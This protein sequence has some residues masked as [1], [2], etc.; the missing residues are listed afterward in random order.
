MSMANAS[1]TL[2]DAWSHFNNP[3]AI[4]AVENFT[5]G[6]SYENRFLLKELQSQAFAAAIPLKA[7]VVSAGGQ[8]FGYRDFRTYKAGVGYGLKLS[9]KL[10]A[11]VQM[12]YLGLQLNNA[13]GSKH[14]ISGDLGVLGKITDH[15]LFGVSVNNLFRAKLAEY[16]DDRFTTKMRF[17]SSYILSDKAII[18]GEVEKDITNP[19]RFKAGIEYKPIKNFCIRG[20]V[21][22]AP[23]ELSFGIGYKAEVITIDVGSSYHQILGWSPHFGLTFVNNK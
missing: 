3:G 17:G 4:G 23:V 15:W 22:T 18:A 16:Q 14:T 10:F 2:N 19:M 6:L 21:A 1:V 11:G 7:G 20:G 13:Y 9:E 5:A 8:M 12:N